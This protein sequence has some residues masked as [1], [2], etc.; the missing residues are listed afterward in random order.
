MN[1][2]LPDVPHTP[3]EDADHF[4]ALIAD[5]ELRIS[6]CNGLIHL[7]KA[8]PFNRRHW[9]SVS[10]IANALAREHD[11]FTVNAQKRAAI[12]ESL[13]DSIVKGKFVAERDKRNRLQVMNLYPS[14]RTGFRFEPDAARN[15]DWFQRSTEFVWIRRD[16]V[17]SWYQQYN[18]SPLVELGLEEK[19]AAANRQPAEDADD[20]ATDDA[21]HLSVADSPPESDQ[22]RVSINGNLVRKFTE[23][24]IADVR[25]KGEQPTQMGIVKAARN[26]NVQVG[27]EIFRKALVELLGADAPQRGRPRKRNSPK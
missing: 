9:F 6:I 16:V 18:V 25:A 14:A 12:V 19:S 2:D 13:R 8:T 22:R 27:R 24:Y 4:A 23:D 20:R 11:A 1:T 3:D 26:A 17:L 5:R 10:E 15:S 7:A 21:A